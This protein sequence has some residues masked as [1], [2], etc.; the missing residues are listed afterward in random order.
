MLTTSYNQLNSTTPQ[1]FLVTSSTLMN[2]IG[3]TNEHMWIVILGI[4]I[5]GDDGAMM[6][7]KP[8]SKEYD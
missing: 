5:G 4:E 1:P 2:Y 6:I 7:R 8:K 3:S